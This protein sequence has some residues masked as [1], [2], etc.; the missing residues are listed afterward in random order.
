M[1]VKNWNFSYNGREKKEVKQH[2]LD[3]LSL[4]GATGLLWY[5]FLSIIREHFPEYIEGLDWVVIGL[6]L[7]VLWL[8][9]D[10]PGKYL[11]KL[12]LPCH[13]AGFFIPVVYVIVNFER[14]TDGIVRLAWFY[15]PKW[16]SYYNQ[17]LYLGEAG[18]DENAAV[19]FTAIC[20]ISWWL[21][22]TLAYVSK[23]RILLVVFPVLALSMELLVGI[24]PVENGLFLALVAAMLLTTLGGSSICKKLVVITCAGLSIFFSGILF[25]EEIKEL[26]TEKKKQ[27][28]LQLQENF[29][30]EDFQLANMFQ[31]DFH[32]NWEKLGNQSP[33]Y[34]GKTVLEIETDKSPVSTIYIKGFYG[35]NYGDG[36]WSYDASAFEKAC[37]E[38]GK[39]AEEVALQIFQ[40][41]YER[42]TE[43]YKDSYNYDE[44]TYEVTY[45][46]TMGDVAYVPYA[47]DYTSLDE[48]YTLMGDYLLKK[49]LLDTK[50]TVTGINMETKL[51]RWVNVNS[52]IRAGAFPY[53][54]SVSSSYLSPVIDLENQ[55]EELAFLNELANAYL[56]VPEEAKKFLEQATGEIEANM[57]ESSLSY[58]SYYSSYYDANGE[59]ENNRRIQYGQAVVSYLAKQ[60]SYSLKLDT[61]PI[62]MDPIEYA[63]NES[64][65]GYCM[66]FASAATLLL[67]QGGV[68]ARYVSGYAVDRSV[69]EKDEET[70]MYKAEVGDYM[71]HA[72][73][74]IYLDDIGWVYL[75]VTPGSS[76]E[77]LPS[78][79]ELNQWEEKSEAHRQELEASDQS[80]E[81]ETTEA[82]GET[83]QTEEQDS[84]EDTQQSSENPNMQDSQ[85]E[86][87]NDSI[88]GAPGGVG[89]GDGEL[90]L[91]GFLKILGIV[92]GILLLV[93]AVSGIIRYGIRRYQRE[94]ALEIER[95]LTKRAV[96]RINRRMYRMLQIRNP[97]LWFAA[98][99]SDIEY[100]QVLVKQ[101]PEVSQ[102]EWK[103]FM[104]IVKKN[105]YSDE[106]VTIEEMQYCYDCYQ[107]C[108][109]KKKR[110]V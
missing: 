68:P 43:Y 89:S 67:R 16:N 79:N 51:E 92:G 47:S 56:N 62:G 29:D 108:I 59:N 25:D 103:Q 69:F 101:Y 26:A 54:T 8:G 39:S 94:L 53:A 20:M 63:L 65:E 23:K 10:W 105:H 46:G 71:A 78:Q 15:L 98:K 109:Y 9:Y 80:S 87:P 100:E 27:E 74:E 66:H 48:N 49:S 75:E 28:I 60:M 17:N 7:G 30:I 93:A 6:L 50:I 96:K 32:F 91:E 85:E 13:L 77:N 58:S 73:V 37:K 35:T 31:I 45:A 36:N 3:T 70:G 102:E 2:I 5:S 97:K 12:K 86:T 84:S 72:W 4:W 42:W 76:L 14:V 82:T 64:H 88:Q 40:M 95:N 1:S 33:K 107:A 90:S 61:L 11:R 99:L 21:V 41:P 19:A 38:A 57:P 52:A 55:S 83:E 104:E 22:W 44:I 34:T 24:S 81:S 110:Q 106:K 18:N